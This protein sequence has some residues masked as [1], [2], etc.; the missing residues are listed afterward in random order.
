MIIDLLIQK[1]A[2]DKFNFRNHKEHGD[3][4]NFYFINWILESYQ[5]FI[6]KLCY[7]IYELKLTNS[8]INKGQIIMLYK[9]SFLF[10]SLIS[11]L[12]FADQAYFE[13]M[14]ESAKK[15]DSFSQF[16]VGYAYDQG[17][18]IE[19]D[20]EKAFYWYLKSAQQGESRAINNLAISY[21]DGEGTKQDYVK[22][23]Y[24]LL[25][26]AN[27]GNV[28]AINLLVEYLIKEN[29]PIHNPKEAFIWANKSIEITKN[30]TVYHWGEVTSKYLLGKLYQFGIGTNKDSKKAYVLYSLA[31]LNGDS[32]AEFALGYIYQVGDGVSKN[33][34]KAISWYQKAAEQG[35]S[36]AMYNLAIIM[37]NEDNYL[38]ESSA[39]QYLEKSS[40]LND[41]DAQFLLGQMYESG[42][43]VD[44]NEEYAKAFY[45]KAAENNSIQAR[46]ALDRLNN[47][48]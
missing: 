18:E 5:W 25:K 44:K 1:N 20:K 31:A 30:P 45:E 34:E 42:I 26:L 37:L 4:K 10:L 21:A 19:Q 9:I 7:I 3:F 23:K 35:D 40:E 6:I 8:N 13:S 38:D 48:F 32:D 46:E 41:A 39:L 27:E 2:K 29:T 33:L 14:L 15:G 28:S 36:M 22:A 47:L 17:E 24:W 11:T 12:S 43:F 16:Y